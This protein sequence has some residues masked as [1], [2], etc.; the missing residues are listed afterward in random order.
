[1]QEVLVEGGVDSSKL[2]ALTD[3][4]E[5]MA[6]AAPEVDSALENTGEV[7]DS[8]DDKSSGFAEK[9][10]AGIELTTQAAGQ[11]WAMKTAAEGVFTAFAEGA[12][13]MEKTMAIMTA[14]T[15]LMPLANTLL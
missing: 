1:M 11:F 10:G 9:L 6:A 2:G 12:S 7:Y 14:L 4:L 8:L 5:A 15:T 13:P 3:E